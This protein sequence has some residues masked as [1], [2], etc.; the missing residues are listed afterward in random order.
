MSPIEYSQNVGIAFAV[1]TVAGL[2]TA[3]GSAVVFF[4]SLIKLA[5]RKTLASALGL[6]SGVMVY[7]SFA[8][9]LQKSIL[10]FQDAEFLEDQA[11]FAATLCFFMGVIFMIV[12]YIQDISPDNL[13]VSCLTSC[14]ACLFDQMTHITLAYM[15]FHTTV[16]QL[17]GSW[18]GS[19]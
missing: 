7:V 10:S 18:S 19:S 3:I 4:P 12:S 15:S 9:I 14:S 11:F 6:S 2:S 16:P 1:V 17:F 5:N 8:E 13:P